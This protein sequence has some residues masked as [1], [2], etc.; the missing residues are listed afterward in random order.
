MHLIFPY[1]LRIHLKPSQYIR[2]TLLHINTHS[3]WHLSHWGF[4]RCNNLLYSLLCLYF[5]KWMLLIYYA[6]SHNS[7]KIPCTDGKYLV[8]INGKISLF[9]W[10][11]RLKNLLSYFVR[12]Q[13]N[14]VDLQYLLGYWSEFTRKLWKGSASYDSCSCSPMNIFA[15]WNCLINMHWIA[16]TRHDWNFM[17][18]K[19]VQRLKGIN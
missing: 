8:K 11:A 19:G 18:R 14:N 9:E 12:D 5:C 3:A 17:V 16:V 4:S 7:N 2:P 10:A 13:S 6:F 1:K 15:M